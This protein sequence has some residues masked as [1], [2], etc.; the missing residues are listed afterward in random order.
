MKVK[1]IFIFSVVLLTVAGLVVPVNAGNPEKIGTAAAEERLLP[2]GARGTA[3][4]GACLA[5]INGVEALY[6]NPAGIANT[7]QNVEAMFSYM[8]YIADINITNAAV[9]TR[10]GF[11]S[12]A[13]SFQTI[14][15]GEIAQTTEDAPEGTGVMFSP[16]YF[17]LSAAFSRTM[18]D[19]IY[20]GVAVKLVSEKIMGMGATGVALDMGVQ[21]ITAVGVKIGVA[22]K[23]YG[24]GLK[25]SGSDVERLTELPDT[26]PQTPPHRLAFPTQHAEFP[27][28]FEMGVSYEF[29]PMEMSS[30]L[31]M[32]NFRN[33]NFTNDEILGGAEFAYNDMFF[34]RGG[35]SYGTNQTEYAG[36]KNYIFGP[37][38]GG[39]FKYT[40]TGNTRI[41]LDY[42]YRVTE[43]FDD[44][45]I[46]TVKLLF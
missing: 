27:S 46:F 21:Y 29:K 41:V 3:L 24:T 4:G 15:F 40:L 31:I 17:T 14:G 28:T 19:R 39:G 10:L 26:E 13:F 35:Y 22:M 5:N 43:F 42:T 11:G 36:K 1:N 6:W 8:R 2:I 45:N 16:T 7:A 44:S 12:L 18:T 38:F 9:A 37:T 30:L 32:G 34:L 20:A 33:Q 23:N 25:F